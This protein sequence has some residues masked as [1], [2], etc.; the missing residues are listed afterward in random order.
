M[1]SVLKLLNMNVRNILLNHLKFFDNRIYEIRLRINTPVFVKS[2]Y[3][4]YFLNHKDM[5]KNYIDDYY[6]LRKKDIDETVSSLTLNSIH[7]FEKEI[8]NGYITIEGGHRVGLSGDCIYDGDTFKGFKNI[9]SLNI[10]IAKEF[11]ECSIKYLKN[12]ISI[13]NRIYNTLI[14]G[15]PM[16]G[17]TTFL[18]DISAHLS[19]G[20]DKYN[21]KGLD[22]TVIDER[23]ELS[24]VY[25]GAP[26][27]YLGRRTDVLSYCMKKEGFFMSI[28]ALSPGVIICDELGSKED[29]E[30]IQYALKSGVNI[31]ASAHGYDLNDLKKNIY[32]KNMIENN[33]FERA[34]ILKSSKTPSLVKEIIDISRNKVINDDAS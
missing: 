6:K 25:N 3:G 2:V 34:I 16:S 4:D 20:M 19:D 5:S 23:G 17:K 8:K 13:N 27:M 32:L 14:I 22:V 26:Q 29:F 11:K 12:I 33:F 30:I 15:P 7:A 18:R 21:F 24:A 10:R 28:R 1:N 9:T 31:I